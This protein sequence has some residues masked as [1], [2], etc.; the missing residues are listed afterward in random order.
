MPVIKRNLQYPSLPGS[1]LFLPSWLL[2]VTIYIHPYT[3][4]PTFTLHLS[5]SQPAALSQQQ[6][7]ST[8]STRERPRERLHLF[9]TYDTM[10]TTTTLPPTPPSEFASPVS[11]KK[12]LSS[13]MATA[14][15]TPGQQVLS[16]PEQQHI[17]VITGPAGCGKTSV[18]E[19]LH[20]TYGMPYLEGDTVSS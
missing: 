14:H 5:L 10:S 13:S 9:T 2:P 3:Y 20:Q 18:A 6:G 16:P 12:E 17:W 15:A 1:C 19:S 8:K 4:L 7:S 11:T